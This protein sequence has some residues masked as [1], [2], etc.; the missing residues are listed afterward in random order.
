M[1]K[2]RTAGTSLQAAGS[3]LRGQQARGSGARGRR[4]PESLPFLSLTPLQSAECVL[5]SRSQNVGLVNPGYSLDLR[6][7][8]LWKVRS[9]L[10]RSRLLRSNT[11][12]K[13]LDEIYKVY[14]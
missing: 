2:G 7:D 9:R 12:L 3:A 10:Y 1:E 5:L 6:A 13:A 4:G 11:R 14:T 8:E